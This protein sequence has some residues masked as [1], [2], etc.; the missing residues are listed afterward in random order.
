VVGCSRDGSRIETKTQCKPSTKH[1]LE[2][3]LNTTDSKI[4]LCKANMVLDRKNKQRTATNFWLFLDY[5]INVKS[6]NTRANL[7]L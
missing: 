1:D 4:K 5:R 3:K 7:R 2:H 6:M